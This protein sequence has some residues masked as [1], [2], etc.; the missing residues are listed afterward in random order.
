MM[1]EKQVGYRVNK[2]KSFFYMHQNV[3]GW[4]VQPGMPYLAP[5]RRKEH[6]TKLLDKVRGK[7]QAWKG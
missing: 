4:I 7:L 3:A 1:Y 2:D 5:K 6:F